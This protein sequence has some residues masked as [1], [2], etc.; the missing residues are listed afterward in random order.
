MIGLG[1]TLLLLGLTPGVSGAKPSGSSG[2]CR[3]QEPKDFL[4]RR[5]FVRKG[6]V[7]ARRNLKSL[8]Y[9]VEK[10][11]RVDGIG[12]DA[13]NPETAFSH[14]V[15]TRFFG[16]PLT[17]HRAV[18]PALRCVEKRIRKTCQR[19]TERYKPMALG[20]FRQ[21]NTYRGGEVSNHLFGI[22]IDIDPDRNPC[23]G[24]VDPWP[25]HP[26]CQGD[27]ESVYDRTALPRCWVQAFERY[28]FYW[29]GDDPDLR[30]TMH[31]EFL[32]DPKRILVP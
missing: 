8:R 2:L 31:F 20:G 26:A 6:Q 28:G 23:C 29:L 13:L 22:A 9:R 32:G 4:K 19:S 10:Y 11:G 5:Y 17:I 7:D 24:C 18:E 15:S 27:A 3:L 1:L 25:N 14:A 30:D 21:A 16:L 12:L